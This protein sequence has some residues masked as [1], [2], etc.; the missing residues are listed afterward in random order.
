[1]EAANQF[2]ARAGESE[3]QTGLAMDIS[4]KSV[5]FSLTQ[6]FAQTREGKW[7][8]EN[9]SEFGFIIRYPEGKEHITGYQFEPW[10]LRYVGKN[11]S[12]EI[13]S[14]NIT[15]EGYLGKV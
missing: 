5:N 1:M 10:H 2:S 3:H 15:L 9:A 13:A 4:S 14:R 7:L 8:E 6:S 12:L 11:P